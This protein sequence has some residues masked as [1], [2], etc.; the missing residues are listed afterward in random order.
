VKHLPLE[1]PH[2]CVAREAI[3]LLKATVARLSKKAVAHRRL[4]KWRVDA[5]LELTR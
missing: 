4:M 2:I 5:Y 3:L 1:T